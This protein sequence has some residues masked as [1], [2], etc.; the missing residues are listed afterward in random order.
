[1][2]QRWDNA[3]A[4]CN[5]IMRRFFYHRRRINIQAGTALWKK[6]A[7]QRMWCRVCAVCKQW[8]HLYFLVI[9]LYFFHLLVVFHWTSSSMKGRL[10][11]KVVFRRRSSST[12]GCLQPKVV[13]HW[14]LSSTKGCPPPKVVFHQRS[15][16]TRCCLHYCQ[17]TLQLANPTQL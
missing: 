3:G 15:F 14:R 13:F 11:L 5:S 16:S 6:N 2:T 10:P 9:I 1:M 8:V 7:A 17:T 12:K 4:I